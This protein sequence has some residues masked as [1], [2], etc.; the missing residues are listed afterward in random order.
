[1][2]SHSYCPALLVRSAY[3]HS[4]IVKGFVGMV[5]R[6]TKYTSFHNQPTHGNLPK[7]TNQ[8]STQ[9]TDLS[10]YWTIVDG[11]ASIGSGLTKGRV[12]YGTLGLTTGGYGT[13]V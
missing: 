5:P 2:T 3:E 11:F 8:L 12:D 6:D 13:L 4:E 7:P 9:P 1:M 10:G